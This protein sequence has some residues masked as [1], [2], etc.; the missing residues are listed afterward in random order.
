MSLN[1]SLRF[2]IVTSILGASATAAAS[3]P[4]LS[5]GAGL[6]SNSCVASGTAHCEDMGTSLKLDL[7]P[8]IKASDH[9][10]VSVDLM[11]GWLSPQDVPSNASAS[12]SV[13]TVMPV[14]RGYLPV[15]DALY[16][17]AGLGL[18]Y[19]HYKMR[20]E[21]SGRT[22]VVKTSNWTNVKLTGGVAY[23]PNEYVQI[24]GSYDCYL[25][26]ASQVCVDMDGHEKCSSGSDIANDDAA[27]L[28]QIAFFV[29]TFFGS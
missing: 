26:G 29:R 23:M 2:L 15:N 16:L 25:M 1:F 3:G 12:V 18:G 7:S 17:F 8:E 24:G 14:V 21:E 27:N 9:V 13:L 19:G 4:R 28:F 20:A 5:L 22:L 10:G 11:H 6:G